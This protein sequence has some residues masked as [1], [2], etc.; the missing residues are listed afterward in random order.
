MEGIN[1]LGTEVPCPVK[2]RMMSRAERVLG[3][4]HVW[5]AVVGLWRIYVR[6][7]LLILLASA[8]MKLCLS[9]F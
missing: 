5:P 3:T 4:C 1:Q 8:L 2:G 7:L 9:H 6:G